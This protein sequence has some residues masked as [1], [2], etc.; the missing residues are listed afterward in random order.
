MRRNPS[1]NPKSG[2]SMLEAIIAL[3]VTAMLLGNIA[4]VERATGDAYES[5][6]FSST[7]EDQ[8]ETTMD[9]I[10]LAVM[11]TSADR[12]DEVLAAPGFVSSIDYEIVTDVVDGEPIIGTPE[13]IEFDLPEGKV[14]WKRAPDTP[15]EMEV[16]WTKNVPPM[17]EGEVLDGVDNNGN[18]INNEEGLAFDL[19]INQIT[20]RL[21]LQRTDS[22]GTEY[23]R[24]L[25]RRVTCRN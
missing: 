20:I 16:T 22:R 5:S 10:A 24:T 19:N 11:S 3:T 18:G 12:L 25:S 4:M 8:A 7:L 17:L 6:V 2:M 1:L 9:R 23:T 14:I 21:T 15:D 13:R